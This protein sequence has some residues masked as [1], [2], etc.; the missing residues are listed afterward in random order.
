MGNGGLK[1]ACFKSKGLNMLHENKKTVNATEFV[2]RQC[3]DSRFSYPV[4]DWKT[5]E[6]W[7]ERNLHNFTQGY[8]QGVILVHMPSDLVG[9]FRCGVTPNENA[10]SFETIYEARREG[11]QAFGIRVAVV[12]EKPAAKYVDIILYH[13]D[14][15]AEDPLNDIEELGLWNIVSVNC[16]LEEREYPIPALTM[17]RNYL[18]EA[19]G[20][21]ADYSADQFADSIWFWSKHSLCVEQGYWIGSKIAEK[22]DQKILEEVKDATTQD[23]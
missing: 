2:K 21:A 3:K 16:R 13:V 15:M 4:V 11:E 5:V 6:Q 10:I 20:T 17:A 12:E 9:N 22:I 8:R 18:E 23:S 14:V 7:T 1:C 19:G